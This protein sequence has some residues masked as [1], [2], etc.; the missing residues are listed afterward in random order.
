MPIALTYTNPTG[1][2][3]LLASFKSWLQTEVPYGAG[4]VFRYAFLADNS[5]A[6]K[7]ASVGVVELQY[8]Q[9]GAGFFGMNVFPASTYP[10]A[11]PA[12]HGSL[13][14]A[15]F[16]IDIQTDS[17]TDNEA[18][19]NAYKIRDRIRAGLVQAGVAN[20]ETGAVA[21]EPIKVLDFENAQ[22]ETGII[23]RVPLE[24]ENAI[25][26][27]Y[28]PPDENTPQIHTIRLLVRLEW[29]ELN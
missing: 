16:Q 18:L 26:E 25:Q 27:S 13:N 19:R 11:D 24:Q 23:A 2:R 14:A 10:L 20:D 4:S 21:V 7:Y 15:L 12:K 17:G 3:N 1:K 29:F 9:P 8:F 5:N 28:I 6:K 22:A